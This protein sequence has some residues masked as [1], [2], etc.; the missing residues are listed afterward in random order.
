MWRVLSNG[1][2]A[3]TSQDHEQKFGLPEPVDAGRRATALLLGNINGANVEAVTADLSFS[4]GQSVTL[5]FL[6]TSCAYEGWHFRAAFNGQMGDEVIA[7]GGGDLAIWS[8][9]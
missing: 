6:N 4:F 1:K 8:G 5:E 2:L 3:I 7:L 9:G